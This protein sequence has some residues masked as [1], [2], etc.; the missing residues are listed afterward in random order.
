MTSITVD[1]SEAVKK[2]DPQELERALT[3][4]LGEG[5]KHIRN[6]ARRY[7]PQSHK[8]MNWKSAKQRRGFF[9]KLR[10]GEI[11]VPYRRG[12]SP[13]SEKLGASWNITTENRS[14]HLRSIVGTRVSYAPLVMDKDRQAAYHKGNW[15]TVQD[16]ARD[17]A[18]NV[19]RFV[20][21]ALARWAR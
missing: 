19:K 11:D 17:Q 6:E 3:V 8:K 13:G 10:A 5:A 4:A 15:P 20:E 1:V 2:L 16:I 7:P 12:Q 14:G 18:N 21:Q 9:A